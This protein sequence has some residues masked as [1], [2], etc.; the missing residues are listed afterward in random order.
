MDSGVWGDHHR[1]RTETP[2]LGIR[3]DVV[4]AVRTA[5]GE[6]LPFEPDA[7]RSRGFASAQVPV[8]PIRAG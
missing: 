7:G 5:K 3:L 4:A 2:G 8:R 1:A 6:C